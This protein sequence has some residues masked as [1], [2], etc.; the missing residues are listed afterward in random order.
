MKKWEYKGIMATDFYQAVDEILK[1]LGNDGW[2]CV[3]FYPLD[4]S[5]KDE[6][7]VYQ[8]LLKREIIEQPAPKTTFFVEGAAC[9]NPDDDPSLIDLVVNPDMEME[10]FDGGMDC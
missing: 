6:N 8:F 5:S 1:G 3:G 2:D 4:S 10:G 9:R 7:R